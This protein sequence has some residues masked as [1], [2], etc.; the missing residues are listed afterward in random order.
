LRRHYLLRDLQNLIVQWVAATARE[1]R[2][3]HKVEGRKALASA[4]ESGKEL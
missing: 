3:V 2:L 4:A 1:L